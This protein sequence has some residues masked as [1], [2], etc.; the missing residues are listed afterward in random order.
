MTSKPT[1]PFS[2]GRQRIQSVME[3]LCVRFGSADERNDIC[4]DPHLG[5]FAAMTFEPLR[6]IGDK[7]PRLVH[8]RRINEN[9]FSRPRGN[10]GG[11]SR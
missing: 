9:K 8:R 5:P 4:K 1:K 6:E 3:L 10:L 2:I 7:R 11:I